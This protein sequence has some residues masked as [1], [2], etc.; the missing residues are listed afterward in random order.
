MLAV[1]QSYERELGG[2]TLRRARQRERQEPR[3]VSPSTTCSR[4]TRRSARRRAT[5]SRRWRCCRAPTWR[6]LD[7]DGV[8]LAIT[9]TE[10]PK[11]LCDR[12]GLAGRRPRQGRRDGDGPRGH[13][14]VARHGVR[15]VRAHPGASNARGH[16][17]AGRGRREPHL[18]RTTRATSGRCPPLDSV[19]Q[20]MRAFGSLRRNNVLYVRLV[21]QD[22]G[23]QSAARRSPPFRRPCSASSKP[24]A[25]APDP[26]RSARRRLGRGTSRSTAWSSASAS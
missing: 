8:D 19:P 17:H 14:A 24:T 10:A 16:P 20:L 12:A 3:G 6:A 7:I 13:P 26:R 23:A 21:N 25:P 5:S 11:T 2:A 18:G 9:S 1:L 22:A 4:A 15:P